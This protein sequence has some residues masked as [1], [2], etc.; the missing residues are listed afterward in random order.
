[1]RNQKHRNTPGSD[2]YSCERLFMSGLKTSFLFSP[3]KR[4]ISFIYLLDY[5]SYPYFKINVSSRVL[6][7]SFSDNADVMHTVKCLWCCKKLRNMFT[8]STLVVDQDE[9]VTNYFFSSILII[10]TPGDKKEYTPLH[11]A[12]MYNRKNCIKVLWEHGVDVNCVGGIDDVTP[13]HLA[14][15]YKMVAGAKFLVETCGTHFF[16]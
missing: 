3:I 10:L 12:A 6:R 15:M 4:I 1:M 16:H 14:A 8:P 13:L 9:P 5:K 2:F 11:Y 7:Y